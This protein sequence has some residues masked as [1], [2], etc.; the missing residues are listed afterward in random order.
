MMKKITLTAAALLFCVLFNAPLILHAEDARVD[1]DPACQLRDLK[2][3]VE[4]L[5]K[6]LQQTPKTNEASLTS[7]LDK[8][9]ITGGISAG[10]FQVSNA[11]QEGSEHEFLLSNALVEISQKD[12]EAP[13]GFNIAFGETTTPSVLG[14]PESDIDLD[15][16]YAA[17]TFTPLPG[18]LIEIGL[19]Q[20][21]SGYECTYTFNNANAF[22]GALASQQPYNAYGA[23]VGYEVKG[24]NLWA[25][26][27]RHRLDDEE[28][29]T[30]FSTANE[31][32]EIGGSGTFS[33]TTIGVYHYHLQSLRHLT[34][35]L[36][37]RTIKN[38]AIA[39]NA[40][41]WRWDDG[42]GSA[43]GDDSAFGA[44]LYLTSFFRKFSLPV[45]LEYIDQGKSGIY[46]ENS[47]TDKIYAITVS[48]T[49]RLRDNVYIRADIAYVR[50][51]DGF[52]DKNGTSESDRIAFAL[53][54]GYTF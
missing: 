38:F 19:L 39:F 46:I 26:Y 1:E 16:E 30:D 6:R 54:A 18:G 44:A 43:H 32:W 3:K 53:E 48:P 7:V 23:R 21:N 4:A 52:A 22:L 36:I 5:E 50:A 14:T 29:E 31:S 2:N 11:G 20:P 12:K 40:D 24:I 10:F 33:G 27:Y 25:G 8:L 15:I 34:G 45:R 42:H 28:Y 47:S 35:L 13:V 51:V 9:S 41:Y 49:Y 17:I 37:E